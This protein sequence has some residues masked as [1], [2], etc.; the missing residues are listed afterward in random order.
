MLCGVDTPTL[1]AIVDLSCNTCVAHLHKSG[2]ADKLSVILPCHAAYLPFSIRLAAAHLSVFGHP[3]RILLPLSR[4][5]RLEPRPR[6][7][8][9][10]APPGPPQTRNVPEPGGG[11]RPMF[12]N[13]FHGCCMDH[14]RGLHRNIRKILQNLSNINAY[15]SMI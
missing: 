7:L 10:D 15:P 3:W 8:P 1:T 13:A 2:R 12:M 6:L 14:R 9:Q 11:A 5:E 4:H